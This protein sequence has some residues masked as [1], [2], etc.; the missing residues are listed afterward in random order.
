MSPQ[1]E[2]QLEDA[3]IEQLER[4]GFAPVVLADA[5]AL[6]QNLRSQLEEFRVFKNIKSPK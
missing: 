2:R 5:D 6:I 4:L 3:L 1:T